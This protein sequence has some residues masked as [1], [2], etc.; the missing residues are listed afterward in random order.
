VLPLMEWKR[1]EPEPTYEAAGFRVDPSGIVD[2]GRLEHPVKAEWRGQIR[3]ALVV[4][5]RLLTV[6]EAG[7][8]V[9]PLDIM[10]AGAW[11]R[12]PRT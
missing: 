1:R 7:I 12:F 11:V 4:G 10:S 9:S 8:L 3:R 2:L 5:E 6:S